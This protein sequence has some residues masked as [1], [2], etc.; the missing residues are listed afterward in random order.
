VEPIRQI[1][2][3]WGREQ[4]LANYLQDKLPWILT[5]TP[6]FYFTDYHINRKEAGGRETYIGDLELKW[7]NIPSTQS[8]IFSYNK[9]QLMAAVPVY[10]DHKE[11]Y[12]RIC[13]RF[14]DALLLVPALALMKLPPVLFTRADTNETDLVVKVNPYDFSMGLRYERV[15]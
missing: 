15:E 5:P 9:L 12:H 8:A 11:S 1:R 10:T 2:A 13:F 3:D 7:L 6:A 4:R 14:T